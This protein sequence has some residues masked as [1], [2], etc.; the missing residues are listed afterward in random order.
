MAQRFLFRLETV[1]KLRWQAQRAQQRAVAEAAR[2]VSQVEARID[3]L[4][5]QQRQVLDQTRESQATVRLDLISLR[6]EQFYRGWLEREMQGS[7][8]QLAKARGLLQAEREKL[9]EAVK[10]V[11]VI[12]HLR[13]RQLRRHGDEARRAERA[14]A[15]EISVQNHL[16]RRAL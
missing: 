10:R 4:T 6:R 14:V 15:D 11:K 8:M 16:R 5:E 2:N 13:D 1:R 7:A 12:E 9:A 3:E